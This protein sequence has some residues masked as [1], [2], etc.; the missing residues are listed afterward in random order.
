MNLNATNQAA[1]AG[2]EREVGKLSPAAAE[3]SDCGQL[4]SAA[5]LP[6]RHL[7][8]FNVRFAH[9]REGAVDIA[10]VLGVGAPPPIKSDTRVTFAAPESLDRMG[11]KS[12]IQPWTLPEAQLTQMG[13]ERESE[14]RT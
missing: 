5:V 11:L 4:K 1:D 6:G 12:P 14:R 13:G 10:A 9:R 8:D 7:N 2:W 3:L